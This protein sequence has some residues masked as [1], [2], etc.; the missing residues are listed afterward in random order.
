MFMSVIKAQT[1]MD[2]TIF[3]KWH[4]LKYWREKKH[5]YQIGRQS[6]LVENASARANNLL[7]EFEW[8]F[9]FIENVLHFDS[10]M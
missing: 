3:S 2:L 1:R 6:N 10:H 4:L 8:I 7:N 9:K 5:A